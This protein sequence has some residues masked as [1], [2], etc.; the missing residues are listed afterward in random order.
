MVSFTELAIKFGSGWMPS[1][2]FL[3]FVVGLLFWYSL[4]LFVWGVWPA[5]RF[6]Y[7]VWFKWE[8]PRD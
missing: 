4:V 1:R 5:L 7:R 8:R 6:Y 3:G 2:P